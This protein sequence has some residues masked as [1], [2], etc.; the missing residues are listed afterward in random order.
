MSIPRGATPTLQMDMGDIDFTLADYIY[1]TFETK[2]GK[3]TKTNE[4]LYIEQ[5]VLGVYLT[6]AETLAM[7]G[8]YVKLQVNLV[9]AD[10]S[11]IPSDIERIRLED[12]LE[13]RVLP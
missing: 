3:L 5:H 1:V 13:R 4:D 9:Y 8:D 7:L 2:N 10:G 12:N 11:R 6:Q